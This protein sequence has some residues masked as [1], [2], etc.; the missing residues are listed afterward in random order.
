I[1]HPNRERRVTA[2]LVCLRA[3]H[4]DALSVWREHLRISLRRRLP[5][6]D[7]LFEGVKLGQYDRALKR[8]HASGDTDPGV[9]ISSGL[10]VDANLPHRLRKGIIVGEYRSAV[11]VAA[12]RLAREKAGAS[13]RRQLAAL[14]SPVGRSEALRC[15]LDDR[16]AEL[17]RDRVDPVHIGRMSVE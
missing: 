3:N 8:V 11:A 14:S 9:V 1:P 15:I 17:R 2:R 4:R 12:E 6:E 5:G 13:D 7:F 10:T 16:Y